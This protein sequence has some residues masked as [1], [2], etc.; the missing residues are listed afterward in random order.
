MPET[1]VPSPGGE[2]LLE[3]GMAT[4]GEVHGQRSVAGLQSMDR[5]ESDI[6]RD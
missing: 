5:K 6:L 1:W 4:H 2:D 3:K